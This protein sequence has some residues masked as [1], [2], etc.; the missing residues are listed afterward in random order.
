MTHFVQ[1]NSSQANVFSICG[2]V[3][4]QNV[5]T[6]NEDN[7][8]RKVATI[9]NNT[10]CTMKNDR[11]S[12]SVDEDSS[13]NISEGNNLEAHDVET[14][15]S[16]ALEIQDPNCEDGSSFIRVPFPGFYAEKNGTRLV[17]GTCAICLCDYEV[18]T[19]VVWSSNSLCEHVFHVECI[20]AW[21][22]K[23]REGPLCPCCRRDFVI[24][25]YD[26]DGEEWENHA[27]GHSHTLDSE[28]VELPF[29]QDP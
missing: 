27:V 20:E 15:N 4:M 18:G 25:P 19:D 3:M 22:I 9:S 16:K 28:D 11:E 6:L 8:V 26:V 23:Q 17:P 24:D 2:F 12:E 13:T 21:L 29:R 5:Q 10:L 7:F 1:N 14:G